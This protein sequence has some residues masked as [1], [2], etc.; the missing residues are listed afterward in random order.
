MLNRRVNPTLRLLLSAVTVLA[1]RGVPP[2]LPPGSFDRPVT[3]RIAA[4][5]RPGTL[6]VRLLSASGLPVAGSHVIATSPGHPDRGA[7]TDINGFVEFWQ[8]HPGIWAVS[9]SG[10]NGPASAR[11]I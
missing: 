8:L 1:C 2:D 4:E 7:D 6:R 11:P 5:D 3:P 10:A 9:A